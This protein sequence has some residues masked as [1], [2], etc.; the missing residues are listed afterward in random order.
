MTLH[1][2]SRIADGTCTSVFDGSARTRARKSCG[3]SGAS[4]AASSTTGGGA[5]TGAGRR[6]FGSESPAANARGGSA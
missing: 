4:G 2:R 1:R 5:R 3:R 6:S